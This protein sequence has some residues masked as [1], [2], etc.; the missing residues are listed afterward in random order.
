MIFLV[1]NFLRGVA[2]R[3]GADFS[4]VGHDKIS[5]GKACVR[6]VAHDRGDYFDIKRLCLLYVSSLP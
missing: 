2:L 4:L 6:G 5:E 1:F 3:T